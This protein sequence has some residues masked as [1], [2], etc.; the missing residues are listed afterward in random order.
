MGNSTVRLQNIV[1]QVSAIGDLNPVFNN[2]G[3]WAD[4]PALTIANDVMSELISVRFPW[5]WNRVKVP[6]FTLNSLQQDYVGRLKTIGWLENGLRIDVNNT[7]YPQPSWP[8]YAVRDLE[9]S[10][11][12]SAF[13]YQYC[14]F[15]NK[16]LEQMPWPGPQK[17]YTWPIGVSVAPYNPPTNIILDDGNILALKT[18]GVTGDDPPIVPPWDTALG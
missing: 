5:K 15:Y 7:T 1:D 2:T 12:Q 6:P 4:E 14:W 17:V 11:I 3:G 13:P 8:I 18:Y 10:D 16:D 9:M